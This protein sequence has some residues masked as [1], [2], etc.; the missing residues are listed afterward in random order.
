MSEFLVEVQDSP[1]A[2]R[3]K[4][5][6]KVYLNG[7]MGIRE[8]AVVLSVKPGGFDK[9]NSR[10][11]HVKVSGKVPDY[12]LEAVHSLVTDKDKIPILSITVLR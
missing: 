10:F 1:E 9:P 2:S 5:N 8:G 12:F 3:I 4:D 6:S 11:I 7:S